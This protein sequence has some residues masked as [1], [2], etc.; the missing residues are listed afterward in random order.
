MSDPRDV[1][2]GAAVRAGID[3]LI[4]EIDDGL[5]LIATGCDVDLSGFD[6]RVESICEAAQRLD[7]EAALA[8][9][10]ATLA[11]A[12]QRKLCRGEQ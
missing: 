7:G 3:D 12:F 9:A 8:A 10:V 2:S 5:R 11:R 4:A 6:R 1:T